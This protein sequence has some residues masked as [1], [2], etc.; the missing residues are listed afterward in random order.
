MT[1]V[2]WLMVCFIVVKLLVLIP[3]FMSIRESHRTI[4]ECDAII[5]AS[6]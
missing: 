5:N 3:L 2:L 1:L 6:K 4:K